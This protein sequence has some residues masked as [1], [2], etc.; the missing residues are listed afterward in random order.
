MKYIYI[1]FVVLITNPFL[2]AS[3]KT[4]TTKT[5]K[6]IYQSSITATDNFKIPTIKVKSTC[7][8]D[9]KI[10][11]VESK[12]INDDVAFTSFDTESELVLIDINTKIAYTLNQD[13]TVKSIEKILTELIEP[14][15][16]IESKNTKLN[17]STSTFNIKSSEATVT[18]C[19]TLG[20]YITI[21]VFIKNTD[22]GLIGFTKSNSKNTSKTQ[23]TNIEEAKFSFS[24]YYEIIKSNQ[25]IDK[26]SLKSFSFFK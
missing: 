4:D 14:E 7:F 6:F 2:I 3:K 15:S 12:I 11:L 5:W 1:I 9:Q 13:L 19:K 8:T 26:N 24:K 17:L 21:G 23:L 16:I 18:T 22:G 25:P 20:N 10:I